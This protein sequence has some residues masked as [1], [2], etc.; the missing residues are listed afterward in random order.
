M[1]MGADGGSGATGDTVGGL[2]SQSGICEQSSLVGEVLRRTGR[3]VS[4]IFHSEAAVERISQDPLLLSLLPLPGSDVK[5]RMIVL[6]LTLGRQTRPYEGFT[7]N[8]QN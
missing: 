7:V 1:S 4:F 3:G 2:F 5:T 8:T 6:P